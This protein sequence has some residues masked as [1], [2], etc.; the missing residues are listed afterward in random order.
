MTE[1]CAQD[2]KFL[3]I[4]K[5]LSSVETDMNTVKSDVKENNEELKDSSEKLT[6]IETILDTKLNDGGTLHT[7]LKDLKHGQT[8][9]K[10]SLYG[11]GKPGIA[12]EV[13]RLNQSFAIISK[14]S[15]LFI[16][17][18]VSLWVKTLFF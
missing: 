15:W 3:N 8:S 7:Y 9:L 6:R 2:G 13:D 4:E 16:A 17:G 1:P 12:T 5:R 14:V 18:I 10:K 11:N